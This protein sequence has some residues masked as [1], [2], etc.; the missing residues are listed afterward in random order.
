MK[1][2]K[3]EKVCF[4]E[5]RHTY[6]L[7]EKKL[8]SVTQYIS[9]FKSFFDSDKIAQKYAKKH[10]LKKEDVLKMWS[11]KGKES[12][13]MG[14]FVHKIFE[15]Y[16]LENPLE[17]NDKYPKS[18]VAQ[19]FIKDYFDTGKLIPVETEYI[20]YNDELAGQ[21]DC[22][23]KNKKEEYFILDWKTNKEIKY[24]NIWQNMKGIY[25]HLEDCN[26]NHYSIQLE[27]Y[28]NLCYEYDIKGCY[29]VH[30]DDYNYNIIP[31]D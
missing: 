27:T 13:E 1:Y 29:I 25:S 2:S 21:V 14:T 9:Q 19:K 15:D 31:T 6:F 16:I 8:T 30:L 5:S 4:D 26:F 17:L 10:N 22:I 20:V 3:D 23:A 24:N 7:G 28:K 12:C 18:Y 11:D